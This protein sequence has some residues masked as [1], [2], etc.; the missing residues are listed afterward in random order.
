MQEEEPGEPEAADDRQLLLEAA[1]GL[2]AVRGADVAAPDQTP[3]KGRQPPVGLGILGSG[4]AVAELTGEIEAQALRQAHGLG[5]RRR[6]LGESRRHRL[7][8]RHRRARIAPALRLGALQGHSQP[9]RHQRVLEA[10]T[11]APVRVDVPGGNRR[12]P[13][14]LRETREPAVAGPVAAPVGPLQL[15]P[16][17]VAAEALQQSLRQPLRVGRPAPLPAP[18]DGSLPG[19]SREA[20]EPGRELSDLLQG[21][22]RLPGRPLR[23]LAGAGV[24]LGQQPAEIAVARRALDQ[25]G[26]VGVAGTGQGD[27]QLGAGD[28]A[29]AEGIAGVG[30]LHRP[31]EP[32]VV[33]QRQRR[34]AEPGGGGGELGGSRG[35]VE[36]RECGVAVQLDVGRPRRRAGAPGLP[37]RSQ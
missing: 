28:R 5:D 36:E 11:G 15:D 27:G 34:V 17:A 3:A 13:Q 32:V 31:P 37:C 25:Q 19:T 30:E 9:H 14:P 6:V 22:P 24:R 16:E 26:Q 2:R 12:H 4:I 29:Q 1:L 21:D 35:S 18:G 23:S 7:R 33:G 10:D 20:D 8:G